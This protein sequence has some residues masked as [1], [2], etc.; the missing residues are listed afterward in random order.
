MLAHGARRAYAGIAMIKPSPTGTIDPTHARATL[1]D[2]I[3][4]TATKPERIVL[5]FA[6]TDY[7]MH[8]LPDGTITG[9]VGKR[10]IGTIH[11]R[12]RRVDV[13]HTGGRYAEPVYGRP[14]RVQG[15]ILSIDEPGNT[16]V[17]GAGMPIHCE[18][19]DKRQKAGEF[20]VGDVVT[21]D[22]LDGATFRQ[23]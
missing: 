2:R 8:L 9:E 22:V 20:N 18:L 19:T 3:G 4:Q 11:A 23:A 13:C 1:L 5:G 16:I 10:I 17:V 12:A 6:N 14:R 21:F 7:Q 15:A